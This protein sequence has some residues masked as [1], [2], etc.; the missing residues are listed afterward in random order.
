M[1][2]MVAAFDIGRVTPSMA[3]FDIKKAEA[4]N[5]T[6][7]RALAPT[8]FVSR[9]TPYLAASG[10]LPADGALSDRDGA[11]LATIAPM[12]QERISVLSEAATMLAFLF[13]EEDCFT[14][15]PDSAAKTL[16]ADAKPVLAAAIGALTGL[17]AWTV[18]GIEAALKTS[19]VDTLGLKPR[20]AFAPVRVAVTGRTVS[21]PLYESMEI[22][23]RDR[24]IARLRRA[25]Q[26]P[27]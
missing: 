8:E 17:S 1:A 23:G 10:L 25:E 19:L 3:R 18:D 12:V 21:P 14:P 9:V 26:F 15:D 27:V 6:H 16:G 24:T 2:E 5:A 13:T 20:K 7:L 22:L 4:I 11:A